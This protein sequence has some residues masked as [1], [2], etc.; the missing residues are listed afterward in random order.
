MTPI[1]TAKLT[2]RYSKNPAGQKHP[3]TNTALAALADAVQNRTPVIFNEQADLNFLREAKIAKEFSLNILIQGSGQEY[4]RIDA[5]KATKIPVIVPL[6]F[7]EAP[8]VDTPEEA[9]NVTLEDLRLYDAAPENAGRLQ[10]AGIPISLTS[11]QLKDPGTFLAQARK[12]IERGL[13]ADAALAALTTTPAKWIGVEKQYGTLDIGKAANLIVTDGDLFAEKTKIQE[14]WVDG[15]R[16]EVKLPPSAD[17]R[18]VWDLHTA[19]ENGTL[20]LKGESRQ[21]DRHLTYARE[22]LQASNSHI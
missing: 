11:A 15:K 4:R 17:A 3:E 13:S 20:T 7:P 19:I 9:M 6:N 22:R 18:G 10:N 5:I 1:G 21:A 8:S 2:N 12:A 16:Y 14:V